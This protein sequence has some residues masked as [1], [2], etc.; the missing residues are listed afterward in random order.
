MLFDEREIKADFSSLKELHLESK[1]DILEEGDFHKGEAYV[2][3]F[4]GQK[5]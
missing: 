2:I 3:N 4:V 5:F 1:V